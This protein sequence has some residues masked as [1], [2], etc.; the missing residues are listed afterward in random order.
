LLKEGGRGVSADGMKEPERLGGSSQLQR[1]LLRLRRRLVAEA[2]IAIHMLETALDALWRGDKEQA[3]E[4]RVREQGVDVEEVQI[5]QECFR[6]LTLHQPFAHDFRVLA[7]SLKVNQ[8][9]ERVADHASSIAKITRKMAGIDPG[10][11]PTALRD[12]GERVPLLCHDLL[13]AVLKE[14]VEGARE[15]I[16]KDEVIDALDKRLYE[17]VKAWMGRDP[18]MIDAALLAYRAGRE[19]ERVGDLMANIAEDLVYLVTGT[20]VRHRKA[21]GR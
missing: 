21:P 12:M 20:I 6:L 14:D 3:A 10:E 16:R 4:V 5:E 13:R 19:L 8:D 2:T 7:F 9:L 1:E 17:E 11:W 18:G 15:I